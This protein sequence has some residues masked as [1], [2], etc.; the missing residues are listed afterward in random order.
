MKVVAKVLG[1]LMRV[2]NETLLAHHNNKEMESL[3]SD[4]LSHG[5]EI[6]NATSHMDYQLSKFPHSESSLMLS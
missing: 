2:S 5:F 6:E 1:N 3:T 4:L